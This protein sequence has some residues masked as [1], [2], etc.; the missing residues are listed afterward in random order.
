MA[1]EANRTLAEAKAAVAK[2]RAARGYY[3]PMGMKGTG[4]SKVKGKG[5]LKTAGKKGPCFTCGRMGHL[6]TQCP[7]RHSQGSA[8]L[9]GKGKF[10]GSS[11]AYFTEYFPA[12]FMDCDIPDINVL[13]LQDNEYFH[14][15][16]PQKVILDTGATESVAGVA[17]VARRDW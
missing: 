11:K 13:S 8:N 6:Y 16:P 12:Y 4:K 14:S 2:V 7:D 9:K 15:M 3:D 1:V 17:A 5:K 10:K